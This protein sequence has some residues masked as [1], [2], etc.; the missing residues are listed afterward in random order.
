M[1]RQRNFRSKP[2]VSAASDDEEEPQ[3]GAPRPKVALSKSDKDR[4]KANEQRRTDAAKREVV[5]KA[6]LLSFGEDED[7]QPVALSKPSVPA[8]ARR[9]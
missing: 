6:G 4:Q 8:A 5:K 1:S 3:L 2:V 9:G 7:A